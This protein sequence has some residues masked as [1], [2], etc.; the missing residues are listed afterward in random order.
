MIKGNCNYSLVSILSTVLKREYKE[1]KKSKMIIHQMM[2]KISL[3]ELKIR[4]ST[5]APIS[6]IPNSTIS[7]TSSP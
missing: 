1:M 4:L 7:L 3:K 6:T 5:L 2:K